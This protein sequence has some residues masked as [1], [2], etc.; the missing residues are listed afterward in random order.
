MKKIITIFII[1][2][3]FGSCSDFLDKFPE[4]SITG[5]S[6]YKTES[7][8]TQAINGAYSTLRPLY[9]SDNKA[10]V[11]L[12]MH[13]D[14]AHYMYYATDQGHAN[15]YRKEIADFMLNDANDRV[16]TMWTRCYEGIARTNAILDYIDG[17]ALSD[18]FKKSIIGQAKFLR[19][20]YY[21]H[22]VQ[23]YGGV[24]LQLTQVTSSTNAFRGRASV[25]DVYAA[26]IDDVK[27]AVD[28]LPVV[29]FNDIKQQSG[30]ATKGAA[31]M[32]Y[33]YVLM[34]KPTRDYAEAEKQLKDILTMGYDLMPEYA[35]AFDPD[36]KNGIE[37]IFE[38]QYLAGDVSL[39]NDIIY[40]FLP[41]TS[42]SSIATNIPDK[43][44]IKERGGWNTPTQSLIRTY[45]PA[46]KRL[47]ATI[48]IIIGTPV[49]ANDAMVYDRVGNLGD[50]LNA[51]EIARPFIRKYLHKQLKEFNNND[52]WP[53]YRYADALLLLSECLV[54]QGK[55]GEAQPHMNKVRARAGLDPVAPTAESVAA[56]RRRE[57]AFENHRWYDLLRYGNA[58][59]TIK[60]YAVELKN[61]IANYAPSDRFELPANAFKNIYLLFPIPYREMNIN[62]DLTQNPGY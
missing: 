51:G 23:L 55:A 41:R 45:D 25:D 31:K 46:D 54:E 9:G 26:I 24:P 29:K 18:G 61:D 58:E 43:G 5:S 27:T 39:Q 44:D 32:L 57:L 34:T 13:S 36:K 42:N 60:A 56:E 11:M 14:N 8:F 2:L 30:H 38:V 37:S 47:N 59:E 22:L 28:Y 15:F 62:K 35:D 7:D 20:F 40:E 33:A 16:A 3:I 52:N 17:A 4:D 49:D 1:S 50:P 6:F 53:V 21:F 10:Y 19:A 48:G 12:E